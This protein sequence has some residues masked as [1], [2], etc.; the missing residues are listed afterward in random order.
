MA[1]SVVTD[2][3]NGQRGGGNHVGPDGALLVKT[4]GLGPGSGSRKKF[5]PAEGTAETD[6]PLEVRPRHEDGFVQKADFWTQVNLVF[7]QV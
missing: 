5:A 4:R 3:E 6:S 1:P 2:P 7:Y